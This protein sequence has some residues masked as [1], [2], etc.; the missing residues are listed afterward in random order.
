MNIILNGAMG[1]MGKT[2][3]N[4]CERKYKDINLIK[5]DL[6]KSE[7]CRSFKEIEEVEADAV[8][9]F[10]SCEGT[11]EALDF[12]YNKK[13]PIVIGTTGLGE[14]IFSLMKKYSKEISVFYSPN[15]SFG[16]NICFCLVDMISKKIKKDIHIH[17]TH[18]SAKKDAPSGTAVMF[19]KIIENN[20]GKV[21][22]TSSRIGDITGEHDITFALNGEKIVVSHTAYSRE[23]FAEGA[24]EA[25]RWILKK[26]SGFYNF[27]D[28]LGF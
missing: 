20:D 23:I 27:K 16:I 18:H 5:V 19:K 11:K 10:S 14:D 24:I 12:A 7:G 22:V 28:M 9:D 13:M 2:V 17:E 3:S 8:I 6:I 4:L 15:M 26:K 1:K 21:S 25:A